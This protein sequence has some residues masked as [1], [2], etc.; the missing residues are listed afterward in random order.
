MMK[1]HCDDCN[2]ELLVQ[3]D[4]GVVQTAIFVTLHTGT[5]IGTDHAFC[6]PCALAFLTPMPAETQMLIPD[7]ST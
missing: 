7:A 4:A 1:H 5:M 2:K 3:G 6:V